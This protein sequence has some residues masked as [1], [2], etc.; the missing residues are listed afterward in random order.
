LKKDKKNKQNTGNNQTKPHQKQNNQSKQNINQQQ[1]QTVECPNQPKSFIETR[2]QNNQP[3]QA[4][5][6][7]AAGD[8]QKQ[9]K[10]EIPINNNQ[11]NQRPQTAVASA[12]DTTKPIVQN[13]LNNQSKQAWTHKAA[14]DQQNQKPKI[15]TPI[16]NNQNNQ[17][18][19]T[20]V[21]SAVDTSKPTVQSQL[22]NQSKQPWTYQAAGDQ[23][24]QQQKIEIP[25][26]NNQNNQRP[27][28]AVASG[29]D[30]TKSTVQN[31][32]NNQRPDLATQANKLDKNSLQQPLTSN[33]LSASASSE[34]NV[35]INSNKDNFLVQSSTTSA[36]FSE[37]DDKYQQIQ[38]SNLS[39]DKLGFPLKPKERCTLGRDIRLFA[40]HYGFILNKPFEI[41]HYD[42][43]IYKVY[44]DKTGIEISKEVKTK[45]QSK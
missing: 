9:Q 38:I 35:S 43:N 13:Q 42:I 3:K 11:N 2:N 10:I 44:K 7:Q 40:N 27:Q 20:A 25:I 26:N 37:T 41:L 15:E 5:S 36:I 30:T 12:V 32:L 4:W 6:H 1:L 45:D 29:V 16:N 31:Q 19:Q 33:I 22:N 24:N 39:A 28:T 8:L 14:G 18:P 34:S 23:Q 21:A 17:R